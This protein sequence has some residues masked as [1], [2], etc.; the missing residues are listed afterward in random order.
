METCMVRAIQDLDPFKHILTT[1]G[2]L[3]HITVQEKN[4]S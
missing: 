4:L 3:T 2:D 1:N